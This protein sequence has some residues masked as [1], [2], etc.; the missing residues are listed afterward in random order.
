VTAP[1]F[2]DRLRE[3]RASGALAAASAEAPDWNVEGR[4]WPLREASRFVEAGG[5]RWHVQTLGSGPV[6]LL[7][8]GT[9]AATHSWRDLAPLLARSFTVVAPDLPGH[10]FTALPP[11]EGLSL[12]GMAAS[13]GSLVRAL[14]VEPA[15]AVGHSAGAAVLARMSLD[16]LIAPRVI[17][18]LN[19]AL[20]P[21]S[22]LPGQIFSPLAKLLAWT[23][24][25][26]QLFAWRAND[27][28][29]IDRLLEDTG[30]K[31]EPRGVELYRRLARRPG[32]VAGAFG[33]MANWDLG[34]LERDLPGLKPQLVLV[35]GVED[36]TIPSS[37]A[38]RVQA[39]VPGAKVVRLP[40]LGHLAHE[41]RP[42]QLAAIITEAA[43]DAGALPKP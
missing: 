18:S 38:R 31:L 43:R 6:A 1:R 8:H 3:Q 11:P 2:V 16:G 39:L 34:P 15:L 30:S 33:M 10:G 9:G 13:A 36:G 7:L 35:V 28:A 17:V 5:L 21:L 25:V 14:G 23:G 22:G 20:L 42:E 41:E 27:P 40:G 37:E 19:G 26:P 24:L 29:V 12:P 4:D 32:H